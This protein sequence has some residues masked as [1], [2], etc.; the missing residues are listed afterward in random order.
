MCVS[1]SDDERRTGYGRRTVDYEM[2][3]AL[4]TSVGTLQ[5]SLNA[6]QPGIA[7]LI[8]TVKHLDR[9]VDDM[10]ELQHE[11]FRGHATAGTA[12]STQLAVTLQ[13]IAT[14]EE[15]KKHDEKRIDALTKWLY[16]GG[17]I[18]LTAILALIA[19][20]LGIKPP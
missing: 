7:T 6:L 12:E 14:L 13:R 3:V 2:V 19:A 8:E 11:H 10:K 5:T 17:G 1:E 9:C 4:Q 20:A 16:G 15:G 18:S